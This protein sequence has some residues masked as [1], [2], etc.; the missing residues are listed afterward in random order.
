[1]K[2]YLYIALAVLLLLLTVVSIFLYHSWYSTRYDDLI[3]KESERYNLPPALIK[4]L[5]YSY[6]P[7]EGVYGVMGVPQEGVVLYQQS[8]MTRFF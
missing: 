3:I 1:M 5:I 4:A 8:M 2:Y 6:K 7:R